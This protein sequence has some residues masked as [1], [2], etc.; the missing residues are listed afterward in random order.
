MDT[1]ASAPEG[2]ER[3][4]GVAGD[5]VAAAIG[6]ACIERGL[7][8][9]CA[10]AVVVMLAQR[11]REGFFDLGSASRVG[12]RHAVAFG[13]GQ[14]R[15]A[16]LRGQRRKGLGLGVRERRQRE[17]GEQAES[18]ARGVSVS[19]R[20]NVPDKDTLA[21]SVLMLVLTSTSD[22]KASRTR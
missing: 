15:D 1:T 11:L 2:L 20:Q 22:R 4:R 8:E 17:R 18:E 16:R 7:G 21:V 6:H 10:D 19:H 5:G 13:G 14:E 12:R 3:E 9:A